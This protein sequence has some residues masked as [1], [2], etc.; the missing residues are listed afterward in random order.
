[1]SLR[2]PR[3]VP[4]PA[5]FAGVEAFAGIEVLGIPRGLVAVDA[6]VKK[7][8][9]RVVLAS[10]VSPGKFLILL[11]GSVAEVEESL[12]EAERIAGD[13]LVDRFMLPFAHAQLEPAVFGTLAQRPDGAL[14]IV[15]TA[16]VSSGMR[17]AD[18]AL[19]AAP[20]TLA[21]IHLSVGIGGKC[22][23]AFFGDLFD[24]QASVAAASDAL[25]SGGLLGTEVIPRP[26]AEFIEALGI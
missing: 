25:A 15:E 24:V 10:P 22:W 12:L 21:V 20:V 19:K 1:M 26:H 7:A 14:G 17:S 4:A 13:Q 9:S 3:F 23:Y 11:D 5:S 8:A 16:T 18:A 6:L 2:T